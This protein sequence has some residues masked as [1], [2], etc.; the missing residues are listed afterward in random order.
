M[1]RVGYGLGLGA[2]LL[3]A[4]C[5]MAASAPLSIQSLTVEETALYREGETGIPADLCARFRPGDRQVLDWLA[6]AGEVGKQD[7]YGEGTVSGC[8]VT[9]NL[10]LRD[11][12]RY[13]WYLDAGGGAIMERED[14]TLRYFIGEPFPL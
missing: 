6:A 12:T 14:G 11:G 3:V 7:F 5:A 8:R 13:N 1:V 4:A 2:L 9:G 10:I